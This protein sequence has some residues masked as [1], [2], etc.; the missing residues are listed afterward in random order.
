MKEGN[1]KYEELLSYTTTV[2]EKLAIQKSRQKLQHGLSWKP[3]LEACHR[4][5]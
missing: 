2:L 4:M 3:M 1:I 5:V